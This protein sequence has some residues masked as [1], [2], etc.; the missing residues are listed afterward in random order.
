MQRGAERERR[1]ALT[2]ARGD[3]RERR[4]LEPE[5]QLVE[6]V[7]AGGHT[8]DRRVAVVEALELQHRLLERRVQLLQRVGRAP[9]GDLEDQRL[10]AVERLVDVVVARVRHLLDVARG[11]DEAPEHRELRHDLRV[12]RRVR[13]G[14]RGRLDAQQRRASAECFEM[15]GTAELLGHRDRVDRLAARVQR[16]RGVVHDA[17]RGLVEVARLDVRL[18]RGGDRLAAEHHRPEER[19]LGFEV[20][21]RDAAGGA[22]SARGGAAAIRA[23]WAP[24]RI[25]ERLNQSVSRSSRIASSVRSWR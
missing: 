16:E 18:D 8:D 14:G 4:R 6:I 17:V 21:R 15:P 11:A 2:R 24:S 10:G 19:L 7:V 20:V 1:L 25:V 23:R 3:D 9:L 13:R 5:Q 12:V 22:A